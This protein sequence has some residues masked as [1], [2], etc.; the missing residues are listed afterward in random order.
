MEW[1]RIAAAWRRGPDR[2]GRQREGY[3]GAID[4][5]MWA[6]AAQRAEPRRDG[7][8]QFLFLPNKKKREE[9]GKNSLSSSDRER[10]GR[11]PDGDIIVAVPDKDMSEPEFYSQEPEMGSPAPQEQE[12]HPDDDLPF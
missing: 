8:I 12:K 10:I 4:P 3:Q 2:E 5:E 7:K 6:E 9:L 11:W 1:I